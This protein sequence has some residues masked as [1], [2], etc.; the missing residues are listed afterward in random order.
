MRLF[1]ASLGFIIMLSVSC[2]KKNTID[3][4][5]IQIY[6]LA[7]HESLDPLWEID[8]STIVP[9]EEPIIQYE[10]ILSYDP[11]GHAFKISSSA[12]E[13]FKSKESSI[14]SRPFVLV[15][16]NEYIYTGYFWAAYSSAI[17]PWLTIDPIRAQYA[18]ELRIA[19]GY[20]WLMEDMSIPDRRNDTR[21][22][23]ILR[24]DR[25]LID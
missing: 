7:D 6:L 10:D 9:E 25:K 5:G 14:H 8:E 3:E 17:C 12:Q 22:L 19:L 23:N 4:G 16:N 21:I 1:L 20:P 24:Q 13:S 2:E 15:A 11:K 18:G